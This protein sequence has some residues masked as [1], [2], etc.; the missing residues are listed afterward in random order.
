MYNV[1][2][3]DS[4]LNL[5]IGI[6]I[7]IRSNNMYMY[8]CA[9]AHAHV[10]MYKHMHI[11]TPVQAPGAGARLGPHAMAIHIDIKFNIL[12]LLYYI[13]YNTDNV[14]ILRTYIYS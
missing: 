2:S 9:H 11:Y 5:Y 4:F 12:K 10:H 13:N 14:R 3:V 6:Q 7:L 1:Y 8:M